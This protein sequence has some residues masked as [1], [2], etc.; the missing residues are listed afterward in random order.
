MGG[1]SVSMHR[2]IMRALNQFDKEID[3]IHHNTLDNRKSQLRVVTKSENQQN[4]QRKNH[5]VYYDY[6]REKWLAEIGVNGNKIHLGAFRN[7]EN[8]T[9]ARKEAEKKYH[10]YKHHL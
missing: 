9:K 2:L 10:T 5:G 7:R 6:G 1:R 8:A 3:H 4:R